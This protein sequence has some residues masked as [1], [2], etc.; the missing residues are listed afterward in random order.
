MKHNENVRK[1][2]DQYAQSK[3]LKLDHNSRPEKVNPEHAAKIDLWF[4]Q[5][6]RYKNF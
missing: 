4:R 5:L 1:I 6:E 3:G 2:A